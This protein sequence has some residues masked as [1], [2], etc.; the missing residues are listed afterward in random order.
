MTVESRA[1]PIEIPENKTAS[2]SRAPKAQT[3]LGYVNVARDENDGPEVVYDPYGDDE[4]LVKSSAL[5]TTLC[6]SST[7]LNRK[8]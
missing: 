3:T 2:V 6:V 5:C 8:P 1:E 7:G 4:V